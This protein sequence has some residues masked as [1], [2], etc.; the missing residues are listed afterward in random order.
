MVVC[1]LP[2]RI[3]YNDGRICLRLIYRWYHNKKTGQCEQ[4]LY[5]G[6]G[7]NGNNFET[8]AICE[9]HC[10]KKE[11]SVSNDGIMFPE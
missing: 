1:S 11:R 10:A 3:G 9:N 4:F 5:G 6:C 2:S 7:G 8:K